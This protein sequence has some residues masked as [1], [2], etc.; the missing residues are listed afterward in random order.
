MLGQEEEEIR[1]DPSTVLILQVQLFIF[2]LFR[3]VQDAILLVLHY[4]TMW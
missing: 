4:K 3:D 1:E 2:E